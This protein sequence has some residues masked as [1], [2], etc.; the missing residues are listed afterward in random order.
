MRFW[1]SRSSRSKDRD[2]GVFFLSSFELDAVLVAGGWGAVVGGTG[3][4]NSC[5][6]G[7]E[8]TELAPIVGIY[9]SGGS[10]NERCETDGLWF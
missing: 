2:V 7:S 5:G 10:L 6:G 4:L 9:P 1:L 3:M 8:I